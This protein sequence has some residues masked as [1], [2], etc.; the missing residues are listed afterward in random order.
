MQTIRE[1]GVGTERV[2]EEVT[3]LFAE[4]HVLRMDSDTTTR[5]GDH[6]R[7]LGEFGGAGDV[8]VG[9]QM[10]AK[11]LDFPTVTLVGVVA[12]D[13]GLHIPDFRAAERAFSL[14]AQVCGRSGRTRPGEAIVQTYSPEHPAIVFAATH[15]YAGFAALELEER[16]VMQFPPFARLVYIG[17]IGRNRAAVLAASERY[18]NLLRLP[19]IEVLGPAAYPIARVNNEWRYRVALKTRKPQVLRSAI[20]ER[21][22]PLAR[23]DRT[24]RLAVNVD[25]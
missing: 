4:A 12:A 9:T 8:L 19:E 20:R 17:V 6:A 3:K 22:L 5:I 18:A 2:A 11:G 14:T 1:F 7:I 23:S 25:P 16:R 15:D 13:V 10:V 21:I 24:T